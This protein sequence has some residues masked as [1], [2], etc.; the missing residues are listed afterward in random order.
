MASTSGRALN[1]NAQINFRNLEFNYDIHFNVL[2]RSLI[3]QHLGFCDD[4]TLLK[5]TL[6][7]EDELLE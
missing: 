5:L 3:S 6:N 4:G 2:I 1:S 7:H